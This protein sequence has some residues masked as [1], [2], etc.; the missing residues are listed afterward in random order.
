VQPL[1]LAADAEAGF[2]QVL[3]RS[4]CHVVAHGI[5]VALE[6]LDKKKIAGIVLTMVDPDKIGRYGQSDAVIYSRPLHQY[7]RQ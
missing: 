5:A 4:C 6:Q 1:R 7:Y 3:D 2:I